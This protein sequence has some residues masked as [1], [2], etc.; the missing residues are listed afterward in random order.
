MKIHF[1]HLKK[2]I[3]E[4]IDIHT[5]SNY[6]FQ[7]GHEHEID[8]STFDI[9]FTP[10]RGDCLSLLGLS[11]DLSSLCETSFPYKIYEKEI[12]NF[13]FD[14]KNYDIN[15]L[16]KISFLYVEVNKNKIKEYKN[17]LHSFF[18]D[19]DIKKNNFF[20]DISNYL[21][22]ETGL[23]THCYDYEKIYGKLS[24][25]SSKVDC[26]FETVLD[27]KIQL[28][29]RNSYFKI[30]NDIVNLAGVMGGKS[31]SCSKNTH[32]VLIECAHFNPEE[33]IGKTVK[34]GLNSDAAYK[35]ERNV[36]KDAQEF[37][38]RRFIE[39][40]SDH[41]EIIDL[42]IFSKDYK[43]SKKIEIPYSAKNISKIIGY[44]YNNDDIINK[45][46]SIGFKFQE[47][48]IIVPSFRSD[49]FSE[50][51][52]A[53]EIL[54]IIGYDNIPKKEFLI[55]INQANNDL[56]ERKLKSYLA[57]LGLIEVINFPF[58]SLSGDES[59]KIDNPIDSNKPFMRNSLIDSLIQ[60][61]IYN[62]KRNKDSIKLYEI[63]DVYLNKSNLVSE[64]FLTIAVSGRLG[65]N[66][67]NFTKKLDKE[68]LIKIFKKLGIDASKYI[69]E[70]DRSNYNSKLKNKLFVME[71]PF[72]VI[73]QNNDF[74]DCV[75]I[76][77]SKDYD[78]KKISE[79]PIV[80]RDLSF[81]IKYEKDIYK[82]CEKIMHFKTKNLFEI[83][84][85]DYFKDKDNVSK[86]AFRFIFQSN[87]KTLTDREVDYEIKEIVEANIVK[88]LIEIPGLDKLNLNEL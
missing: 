12:S 65:N 50:N 82:F 42:K 88:D 72:H 35:F 39:I 7:L 22:Y 9:E 83:F 46:R 71:M 67:N 5:L 68:F 74:L 58:S 73:N 59:I 64:K 69:S 3:S 2:F 16:D 61:T 13:N 81:K 31:T 86:L 38:L 45:L 40:I 52:I 11:R 48:R 15:T 62:E 41:T 8:N 23:P 78:Y 75:E 33:I 10:N 4:E 63:S 36:D 1:E 27:T 14:F 85:F 76:M 79:F 21:A 43:E 37:N 55:D 66:L 49:I 53:E 84:M 56:I 60:N 34:Y 87:E 18:F 29:G 44:V 54:R 24:F 17:Y 77:V 20:T 28:S 30:N 26:E 80:Y 47:D 25:E 57:S 19:F 70:I 32:K 51:D 6:L